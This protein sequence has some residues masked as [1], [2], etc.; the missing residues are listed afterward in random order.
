VRA[1]FAV[2]HVAVRVQ[3]QGEGGEL[4]GPVPRVAGGGWLWL[5]LQ[6]A[7]S[8]LSQPATGGTAAAS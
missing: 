2:W 6:P 7:A 1:V 3:V 4:S 5:Q 8:Q